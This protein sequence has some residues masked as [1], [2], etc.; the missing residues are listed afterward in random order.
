MNAKRMTMSL[1]VA[2]TSC[3]RTRWL[4]SSVYL[5]LTVDRATIST[6]PPT[7]AKVGLTQKLSFIPELA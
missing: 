2:V 3:V 7:A 5:A 4:R 6:H 1:R